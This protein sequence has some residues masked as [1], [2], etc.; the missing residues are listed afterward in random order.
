[1]ALLARCMT[2]AEMAAG[3]DK[4]LPSTGWH[5]L[6]TPLWHRF[7]E[8]RFE[9][10]NTKADVIFAFFGFNESFAG[11]KGLEKFRGDLEILVHRCVRSRGAA[12]LPPERWRG[13]PW[14]A[15]TRHEVV[16]EA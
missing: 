6:S 8:N 14:R 3:A 9:K 16:F 7:Q 2:P 4:K 5:D 10:V 1:M 12:A 13:R 15:T 11:P